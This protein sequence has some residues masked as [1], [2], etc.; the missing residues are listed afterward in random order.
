MLFSSSTGI[1]SPPRDV[2]FLWMAS[3]RKLSVCM[4]RRSSCAFSIASQLGM[5]C[6]VASWRFLSMATMSYTRHASM[7]EIRTFSCCCSEKPVIV[8]RFLWDFSRPCGV[9][10]GDLA[11]GSP[12]SSKVASILA[13]VISAFSA[14][15]FCRSFSSASSCFFFAF[16]FSMEFH[17]WLTSSD[18][19]GYSQYSGWSLKPSFRTTSQTSVSCCRSS[20][21][22]AFSRAWIRGACT[23]SFC[24]LAIRSSTSLPVGMSRA[25]T[26]AM[27][28]SISTGSRELCRECRASIA[29]TSFSIFCRT[30][31]AS[32]LMASPLGSVASLASRSR[33]PLS[34]CT[35]ALMF[36]A[37]WNFEMAVSW[38]PELV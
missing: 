35:S 6:C 33:M 25:L 24:T 30:F 15:R 3:M 5:P 38:P 21:F 13:F 34:F 22:M 26:L 29:S 19:R 12:F 1:S 36:S 37:V 10:D 20:E 11:T 23:V 16:S 2:C 31:S 27:A 28:F 8:D 32:V 14:S 18:P 7:S 17:I 4:L 9:G